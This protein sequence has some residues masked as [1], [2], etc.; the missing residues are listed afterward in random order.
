MRV[1]PSSLLLLMVLTLKVAAQESVPSDRGSLELYAQRIKPLFAE[2]CYACHAATKQEGG[3][4]LDTAHSLRKGGDSGP[5][6][7]SADPVNSLVLQRVTAEAAEERM[8]PEGE[9]ERLNDAE[10]EALRSW[11]AAGAPGPADEKGETH[12]REHWAFQPIRR[13]AVPAR[14]DTDA[15]TDQSP[16]DAFLN[17]ELNRAG[18]HAQP[19]ASRETLIRRL[20]ID[21]I[22]LPPSIAEWDRWQNDPSPDWHVRLAE[23]LMTDPR[24]GERWARHWMDVWRYSDWWGL[25]DQL[26]NSQKHIW[27]WRDWIIESLNDDLAYDEMVRQM[28]AADELYP[29]DAGRLR[30]TGFLARN[31][32][33]FNRNQW[34]DETVEHVSKAFLGLTMNCAKCHDHKYD[35]LLH[36]DYYQ[37]RA[38]FEPYHVRLDVTPTTPDLTKDGIPRAFDGQLETPTYLLIR[39]QESNPD[40]SKV[41][42]PDFPEAL[43]F[44]EFPIRSVDLPKE[45]WQPERQPGVLESYGRQAEEMCDEARSQLTSFASSIE[46]STET[47]EQIAQ[48]NVYQATVDRALAYRASIEKRIEATR[49]LWASEEDSSA[50]AT[51]QL[52]VSARDAHRLELQLAVAD[53]KL[54]VARLELKKIQTKPEEQATL[55]QPSS[56]AHERLSQAI[57]LA[58]E[59][60]PTPEFTRFVGAAWTPTRFFDSTKDDPT[61]TFPA[62]SSG[63]RSAL[64]SWITDRRNPLAARVAVNH[65]WARHM[66]APLVP[67]VFDF[68]RKGTPP[69]NQALLDWLA[70]EFMDN[71]WSMKHIH[72][73]IVNS[74]AYQRTSSVVGQTATNSM[75]RDPDN[76]L[77]WRRLP[78]RLEA[79]VVRDSILSHAGALDPS[80]GGPSVMPADQLASK[81]RSLYFFHSNNER[82]LFLMTFDEAMVKECY[83]R[84]QSIVPQQALAMTNSQ[85]VLD[86]LTP[87]ALQLAQGNNDDAQFVRRAFELLLA[88]RPSEREMQAS[89]EALTAWRTMPDASPGT[90]HEQFVWTLLNHNDYVTLR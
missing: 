84:D 70:S 87:I 1:A 72:R 28:L 58:Q 75:T 32:F 10:L 18:I 82:N 47:A 62:T 60:N 45:A 88:I 56:A 73:L 55:D 22:G 49:A 33:L 46:G 19:K 37:L 69:T 64:A 40:R 71:G 20:Y 85:L 63:R 27:H 38:F 25:G 65:L 89:L 35:P 6:V 12:W 41:L 57:Q 81:R 80:R 3:L 53:A 26:R 54:E 43:R 44:G 30:A 9:G 42:A 17:V 52:D 11:I 86:H 79:E 67:T 66:G 48:R 61:V 34:M 21:L 76:Y 59:A 90:A 83:R 23:E 14:T 16:I 39:G 31:Y 78:I 77:W 68:G 50:D 8:P 2:R 74:D 51:A 29:N 24:H 15:A 13:P 5:A 36:T 4:R 7:D